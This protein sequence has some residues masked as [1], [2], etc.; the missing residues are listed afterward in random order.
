[1]SVLVVPQESLASF[2][3]Y[4]SH[5][6]VLAPG[7][8]ILSL[9]PYD[10]DL[11]RF[12]NSFP[13]QGYGILSGTSQAAPFI[14]SAV[15][16]LKGVYPRISND[17]VK[18]RLYLSARNSSKNFRNK[19]TLHGLFHLKKAVEAE[20][21][22]V[23]RP[24]FKIQRLSELS[25]NQK[26]KIKF[27]IK[28]YWQS[29][30]EKVSV[31]VVSE[32]SP[33]KMEFSF[34]GL[35]ESESQD[36]AFEF[37]VPN[38]WVHSQ[39]GF[40][41]FI[42]NGGKTE[43]PF[44]HEVDIYKNFKDSNSYASKVVIPASPKSKAILNK[45]FDK[46]LKLKSFYE[47]SNPSEFPVYYTTESL[48][49]G[50]R[51][52]VWEFSS[53]SSDR[54]ESSLKQKSFFIPHLFDDGISY[55][56]FFI[57]HDFNN[58]GEK[59]YLV[60]G[61]VRTKDGGALQ[62]S[63][64][65]KNFEPLFPG[66]EP[67]WRRRLDKNRKGDIAFLNF[68]DKTMR[69]FPLQTSVGEFSAPVLLFHAYP[70]EFDRL[71]HPDDKSFNETRNYILY[72]EPFVETNSEGKKEVF[73]RDRT[74]DSYSFME[75]LR[76]RLM[77]HQENHGELNGSSV[78]FSAKNFSTKMQFLHI[79]PQDSTEE[80]KA[81]LAVGKGFVKRYYIVIFKKSFGVYDI[82]SLDYKDNQ[83]ASNVIQKPIRISKDKIMD[84]EGSVFIKP[85]KNVH[86]QARVFVTQ[87][88]DAS[89]S[90]R[91]FSTVFEN[92]REQLF[93]FIKTYETEQGFL[94]FYESK[95][96]ITAQLTPFDQ[97]SE[98]IFLSSRNIIRSTFFPNIMFSERL[99]PS[100]IERTEGLSPAVYVDSSN[101]YAK[102]IYWWFF[103][104]KSRKLFS[105]IRYNMKIPDNCISL[106]PVRYGKSYGSKGVFFCKEKESFSL[107]FLSFVD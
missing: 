62:M 84:S 19:Y 6:D 44:F 32:V 33:F 12:P 22:P 71:K 16:F 8:H 107:Y 57:K 43:G 66:F 46:K 93:H 55:V 35:R 29:T 105:P 36:I 65:N 1:M 9:F 39:F 99:K 82:Q 72:L 67:H 15:A 80:L 18:A 52:F 34:M 75:I 101:I 13:I 85:Y 79:F 53:S 26:A 81:L 90:H 77:Q 7:D 69:F 42:E 64:L 87:S 100:V 27:Q 89:R 70:P 97:D 104:Q 92:E 63:F 94:S 74:V 51:V 56:P 91:S 61:F 31:T 88:E 50:L 60:S 23:I 11:R 41:I 38:D 86:R 21:Q 2:S 95:K 68:K 4:G 25:S 37:P 59:D 20:K 30:S 96:K 49:E 106:N 48:K 5:I 24:N 58:D 10:I 45:D 40:S 83:L 78:G 76:S 103:D 28:N 17:E 102:K 73:L 3:N 54:S 98:D 47:P 14:S